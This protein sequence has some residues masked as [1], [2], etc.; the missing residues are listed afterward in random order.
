MSSYPY[1]G[2]YELNMWTGNERE[3]ENSVLTIKPSSNA[4]VYNKQTKE[5]VTEMERNI[6]L[7]LFKIDLTTFPLFK[8]LSLSL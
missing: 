6:L 7:E 3:I 2:S 8:E 5:L 4:Y 1:R